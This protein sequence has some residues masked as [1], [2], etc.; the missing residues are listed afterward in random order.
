[1]KKFLTALLTLA[2]LIPPATAGDN[3]TWA[4]WERKISASMKGIQKRKV[5]GR[6]M[7]I[8]VPSDN[9]EDLY[10]MSAES[11]NLLA[12]S[13]GTVL[14]LMQAPEGSNVDGLAVPM[15]AAF[16]TSFGRFGIDTELRD[17]FMSGSLPV[18]GNEELFPREG[19][20][21]LQRQLAFLKYVYRGDAVRMKILPVYVHFSDANSQVKD[22][23]PFLIEEI[24]DAGL[25]LDLLTVVVA[26][27][28]RANS[29]DRLRESDGPNLRSVRNLDVDSLLEWTANASGASL[30][31]RDVLTL[32]LLMNRLSNADHADIIAY[33]DSGHMVLSKDRKAPTSYVA[34]G[35]ASLPPYPT[36]LPHVDQDR[37]L[38]VFDD[39]MRMDILTMTRQACMSAVDPTA[40]KPP[41]LGHKEGAK[42][43]P[44]YVSIYDAQG[45]IL[46]QAG[47][48]VAVGPLEES[49]RRYAV[50]AVHKASPILDKA[51][52]KTAVVDVSIPFGFN[53]LSQADDLVPLLNGVVLKA[54]G[55]TAALHPD[56]WRKYP[57][58][59]Q[60]LAEAAYRLDLAPWA[61]TFSTIKI[62]SFRVLAFNEKEPFPSMIAPDTKRKKKMKT[63]EDDD[64]GDTG[65]TG[66]GSGGGKGGGSGGGG[67]GGGSFGF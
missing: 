65:G 17:K 57:D 20:V 41:E 55:K 59:H 18:T 6:T 2:L 43:W 1:M 54:F 15:I 56:A 35:F 30:A 27:L 10:P 29:P 52:M 53:V 21:T 37:V 63:S 5:P 9:R 26:N 4:N 38:T 12:R 32:G 40:A 25:D 47:S 33:G 60:L 44:V 13:G 24:R 3:D 62:D 64:S 39:V 66:G 14:I 49:L 51:A 36:K 28:T 50:E 67:G 48:Q 61:Y 34:A 58:P 46:G 8:L 19:S 22:F 23:A 31:D 7:G 11:Y 42:K 16:E 45:K